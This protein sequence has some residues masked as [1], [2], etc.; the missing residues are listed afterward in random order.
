MISKYL[1]S[2]QFY[3]NNRTSLIV[4]HHNFFLLF[5]FVYSFLSD[6]KA[7]EGKGDSLAEITEQLEKHKVRL[8]DGVGPIWGVGEGSGL[9]VD[10]V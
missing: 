1:F 8:L 9:I 3:F 6:E 5:A 10:C 7:E 2:I 4:L